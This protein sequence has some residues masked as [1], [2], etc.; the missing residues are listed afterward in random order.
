[1]SDA[2]PTS[3]ARP[4]RLVLL[5]HPVS[6][7]LSPRFQ[8]AALDAA[9][10]PLRYDAVDTP[11]EQLTTTLAVLAHERAVGNVTIPHKEAVF[12]ACAIRSDVAVRVGAVNTFAHDEAGRLCG[13]NTDVAGALGAMRAVL[14]P[15]P[16]AR[17]VVLGSGGAAAAVLE[18]LRL[19]GTT[20]VALAARTLARAD[21]LAARVGL[22]VTTHPMPD[23]AS[24][25][26]ASVR[27][28]NAR[29]AG[30]PSAIAPAAA[31][32]RAALRDADLVVNT[33]PRGLTDDALPVE[34]SALGAQT[35]VLDL[36]YRPGETPWV[37][38][39]RAAG[40][41]AED[42]LR[43]LVEQGAEAWA[44]WFGVVPDREAMWRVLEPRPFRPSA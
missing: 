26:S 21:A 32:L 17:V 11:P 36:V 27:S 42:G 10:L 38:A 8:Q 13:H 24:V 7:S 35:A 34:P 12:A 41:A 5:G 1:V 14:G 40:H 6:H 23:G 9:A 25:P 29:S 4:S 30:A 44:W 37:H 22:P 39:C 20:H 19:A 15:R 2:R 31:A 33:T 43:M 28:A 3:H 18:A 16:P